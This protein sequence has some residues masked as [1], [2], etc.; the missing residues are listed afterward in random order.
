[1]K[2]PIPWLEKQRMVGRIPSYKEHPLGM[3]SGSPEEWEVSTVVEEDL[4]SVTTVKERAP[5]TGLWFITEVER[6]ED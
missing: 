1:M 6:S 3:D 2:V 4:S 5:I